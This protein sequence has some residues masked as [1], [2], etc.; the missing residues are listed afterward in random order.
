MGKVEWLCYGLGCSLDMCLGGGDGDVL[1][2]V[3]LGSV[4]VM[5]CC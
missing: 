3:Y 2:N 4:W 1:I 5:F